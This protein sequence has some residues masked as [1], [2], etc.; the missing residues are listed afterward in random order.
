M[1]NCAT[2]LCIITLLSIVS[3][4]YAGRTDDDL[5]LTNKMYTKSYLKHHICQLNS[6]ALAMEYSLNTLQEMEAYVEAIRKKAEYIVCI[7][8]RDSHHDRYSRS[9]YQAALEEEIMA[10]K[11]LKVIKSAIGWNAV[12]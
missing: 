6:Q 11:A 8:C 1:K 2:K 12:D 10:L 4:A 3:S 9:Q 5:A 7:E